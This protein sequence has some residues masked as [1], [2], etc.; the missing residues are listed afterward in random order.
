MTRWRGVFL[1]VLCA[2]MGTS[3]AAAQW[4]PQLEGADIEVGAFYDGSWLDIQRPQ[5]ITARTL[6]WWLRLTT[7]GS[8]RDPRLF[9]FQVV[10]RPYLLRG[11]YL[12]AVDGSEGNGNGSGLSGALRVQLFRSSQVSGEV[13]AQQSRDL[14]RTRFGGQVDQRFSTWAV[15][16][17]DRN[18]L[19]PMEVS[20]ER[21]RRDSRWTSGVAASRL[22]TD[23]R[24]GTLRLQSSNSRTRLLLERLDYRL[25][26]GGVDYVRSLGTLDHRLSWGHESQ[27]RTLVRYTSRARSR[28]FQRL[29]WRESVHLQHADFISSDYDVGLVR[30]TSDAADLRQTDLRGTVT[31]QPSTSLTLSFDGLLQAWSAGIVER[32]FVRLGPRLGFSADLPKGATLSVRTDGYYQQHAQGSDGETF[33]DVV[34]ERH[35]VSDDS[36]F[37]LTEPFVDPLSVT[38]TGEEGGTLYEVGFDYRLVE[39]D[40]FLIVEVL[41]GSRIQ[42]AEVVLADYRYQVAPRVSARAMEY[43]YDVVLRLGALRLYHRRR[44][45][46]DLDE[47]P[48][49]VLPVLRDYDQ[50]A[51]GLSIEIPIR[52]AAVSLHAERREDQSEQF[53]SRFE[54]LR[55]SLTVPLFADLIAGGSGQVFRLS[56]GPVPYRTVEGESFLEWRPYAGLRIRN[57]VSYW[58]WEDN[59]RSERFLGGGALLE[60]SNRRR[61]VILQYDH[62]DWAEGLDRREDR[63]SIRVSYE[64]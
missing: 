9:A 6:Q 63:V 31:Y 45:R 50:R 24:T 60:W 46:H 42:I 59:T 19:L 33:A 48:L 38:L 25:E 57:Y 15:R 40:P 51:T 5:L 18:P 39:S 7:V 1:G 49:D 44:A 55:A 34:Q 37:T 56:G 11:E 26:P 30:Q 10:A 27:L 4:A 16:F 13:L 53:N 41:P 23:D 28:E 20:Y 8:V 35:V 62:L 32:K 2:T 3:P 21:R 61:T 58:T 17:L 22:D 29:Q 54:T 52:R 64:F 43:S 47:I 14:R 36:R 12:P